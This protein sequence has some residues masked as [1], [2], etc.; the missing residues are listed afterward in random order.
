[1]LLE[2][3]QLGPARTEI[4]CRTAIALEHILKLAHGT[5]CRRVAVDE[6]LRDAKIENGNKAEE[7]GEGQ[8]T[9]DRRRELQVHW[10]TR[11]AIFAEI[12]KRSRLSFESWVIDERNAALRKLG[13]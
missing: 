13:D 12:S 10:P 9:A 3:S 7:N 6:R 2:R 8:S 4:A 5:A 11:G 1:M